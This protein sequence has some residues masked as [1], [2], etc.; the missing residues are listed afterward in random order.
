M[1]LK[2]EVDLNDF[3]SENF[4]VDEHGTSSDQSISQDVLD[5]I[6]LEVRQRR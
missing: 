5:V 4:T 2:I 6:R 1:K 3:Y